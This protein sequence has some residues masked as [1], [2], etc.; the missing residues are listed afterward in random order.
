[1]KGMSSISSRGASRIVSSW[2]TSMLL[3]CMTTNPAIDACKQCVLH[4][5][6]RKVRGHGRGNSVQPTFPSDRKV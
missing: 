6:G 2:E 4:E 3:T 1:M 5:Y